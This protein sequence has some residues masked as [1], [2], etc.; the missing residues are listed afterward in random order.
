MSR[1]NIT[2]DSRAVKPGDTFVAIKGFTVDGHDFIE[3][4][5]E[6]GASRIVC[7]RGSYSVETITV[8]N[9]EKW[10][11]DTLIENYSQEF[12]G[13]SFVGITGTNGK[14]TTAYLVSQMLNALGRKCAYI[15]TIGFYVNNEL[16]RQLPNTTPD[17]LKT[18]ELIL[19]AKILGVD[20]VIME[21][22]SHAL[23]YGRINGIKF[24][25]AAFTNLTEDHL[26]FHKTMEAY[27]ET[28]ALITNYLKSDGVMIV[29][30]DDEAHEAFPAEHVKK[31]GLVGAAGTKDSSEARF[32]HDDYIV[33]SYEYGLSSTDMVIGH[34]GRDFA[35]R[36]NLLNKFNLYNFT[37]A[38]AIANSL[39]FTMDEIARVSAEVYPPSGRNEIIEVNGAKAII[40]YAH[41]PDAVEQIISANRESTSGRIV[42]VIGCGGDRD[43]IKRPIM[44]EIATRL[45]DHVVFTDDN[46]RTEDH[47]KIM[48]D[49]LAGVTAANYEV[50]LD[51]GKAIRIGL[52]ML[53]PGDT[54]LILGKGHEDYQIIGREKI[55]FS[56]REQVLLY[57]ER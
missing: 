13:L 32:G 35:M 45:S 54:L 1:I 27:L 33:K 40:D 20:T 36:T 49:I 30:A 8:E 10:L 4:A 57:K 46:P 52:E 53:V 19:E 42:T 50:E 22:S 5:I 11:N 41:T 9:S 31:I 25:I 14:T 23:Y 26:D 3:K 29:N 17:I 15:G 7:E 44:G 28:K 24:D 43:P 21:V 39:G 56:D 16:I 2:S 51:R 38:A 6:N 34:E 12:E 55:H 47:E 18:Y 37:M 48:S